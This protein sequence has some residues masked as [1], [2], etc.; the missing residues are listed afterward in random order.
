[1]IA[2]RVYDALGI[3]LHLGIFAEHST[4]IGLAAVVDQMLLEGIGEVA[5]PPT[6]VPRDAPL[7]LSSSQ[8]RIWNNSQTAEDSASSVAARGVRIS[9][10]LDP[11]VLHEC[12]NYIVQ[13]H[14]ILRT[15]FAVADG[16]PVQ[17]VHPVTS[18]LLPYIDL[19]DAA[20]AE[21]RASLIYKSEAARPLDLIQ[22]PLIRFSLV[23]ISENEHWLLRVDHH[24]I[25]DGWSW[26]VYFRELALLY[27][28]KLRG[29]A[30]PLPAYEPLQYADYA[31]WQRDSLR[32]DRAAYQEA[33]GWWRAL[34]AR[35]P[36]RFRLPFK[37]AKSIKG[38]DP[39]EGVIVWG[40]NPETS[41]RLNELARTEGVTYYVIRLAVFIAMLAGESGERD[42]VIGTYVSNRTRLAFQNMLGSF[43]NLVTLRLECHL[44]QTFR[45]WLAV[46]RE[47]IVETEARADIPY[48]ELRKELQ[49]QG[50]P[51][52]DITVLFGV[53]H[54]HERIRIA[55]L[56]LTR[57]DERIEYMPWLFTV[58][59]DEHNEESNCNTVF[60]AG[61]YPSN[62][63]RDFTNR[64]VRLIN[65]ASLRPD[66]S[67]NELLTIS[68]TRPPGTARIW[69]RRLN[70]AGRKLRLW[71][72]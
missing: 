37:R 22:G 71:L 57:L 35:R 44:N 43:F 11:K 69:F 47:R 61:L 67:M 66:L 45:E 48:D 31:A 5:P 33:V 62:A 2:A 34:F 13:R 28:A 24:I 19:A 32:P 10:P 8:E 60:D 65:L 30:P 12:M 63:V 64:F 39:A 7:R 29:D 53:S 4:L 50:K 46:V 15:T 51:L 21:E 6:R 70:R 56:T 54:H 3:E 36:P 9:G 27:E 58:N 14:E 41:H 18:I 42:L 49:R 55:D 16:Q 38:V 17:V 25:T 26:K 72:G 40:I 52:P 68:G 1:M 59:F 20:D 23:R